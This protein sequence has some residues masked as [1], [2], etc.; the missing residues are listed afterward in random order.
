MNVSPSSLGAFLNCG[1][2]YY[3]EYVLKLKGKV[4]YPQLMGI[5][6][7][8]FLADLYRSRSGKT[9]FYYKT[10]ASAESS[11]KYKWFK[12]VR[13]H[14]ERLIGY[15]TKS[16]GVFM[17][18]GWKC[19]KNYW[20]ANLTKPDPLEIEKKMTA[21]IMSGVKL[22][23]VLDQVRPLNIETIKSIRPDLLNGDILSSDYGPYCIVDFKTTGSQ[24]ASEG[25]ENDQLRQIASLLQAIQPVAY[26]FLCKTTKG[27][28]PV[29]F[30]YY[31]LQ[32]G[33]TVRID[34]SEDPR[35][36]DDFIE[37]IRHLA[38][39]LDRESFPKNVSPSCRY[40][41]QFENCLGAQDTRTSIHN[42]AL[43]LTGN[44]PRTIFRKEQA[45]NGPK[46]LRLFG[47]RVGSK[48]D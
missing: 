25:S 11:W 44:T 43:P 23:G 32:E 37:K 30:F 6:V 10:L 28:W 16:D 18:L 14:K 34:G 29:C 8:E 35:K 42:D 2:Y 7:H 17:A 46:Q 48:D 21:Q 26:T 12:S 20:N 15:S 13:E 24:W 45:A 22:T 40:C 1:Y 9:K 31:N 3:L 36:Y 47:K 33:T 4:T 5:V 38:L 19:I 39:C 41:T 27:K